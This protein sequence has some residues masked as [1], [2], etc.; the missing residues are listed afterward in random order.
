MALINLRD[1]YP[2]YTHDKFAEIPDEIAS[3]LF[4]DKRYHKAHDRRM[5]RNKA[6]SLDVEADMEAAALACDSTNPEAIFAAMERHCRLCQALNSLPEI[7][8]RRVE[9]H[10]LLGMSRKEIAKSEGVSESSV[11]ESIIRGLR[12]MKKIYTENIFSNCPVKRP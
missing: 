3:E 4:A 9:A 11:N 6:Y 8:G 2:W 1:F 7:Q 10:Y 5:K 12:A